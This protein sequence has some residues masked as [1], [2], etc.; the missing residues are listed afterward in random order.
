MLNV[1]EPSY[2]RN[3]FSSGRNV[4]HLSNQNNKHLP[5]YDF[6]MRYARVNDTYLNQ[7]EPQHFDEANIDHISRQNVNNGDYHTQCNRQQNFS[8]TSHAWP[9]QHEFKPLMNYHFT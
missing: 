5:W 1:R 2:I 4:N 3:L 9:V 7:H 8:N 6:D